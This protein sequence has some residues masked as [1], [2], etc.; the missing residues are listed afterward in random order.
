MLRGCKPLNAQKLSFDLN[1][2]FKK[3]TP[4]VSREKLRKE[5]ATL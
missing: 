3:T 5:V 2:R 4:K 1:Q